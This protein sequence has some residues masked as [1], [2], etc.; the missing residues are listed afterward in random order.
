MEKIKQ[1][2]SQALTI[3]DA[4]ESL[5]KIADIDFDAEIAIGE[6]HHLVIQDQ[7]IP[8]QKV[9]FLKGANKQATIEALR[10]I[11]QT[12]LDY[13]RAFAKREYSRL[14]EDQG[15]DDIHTM[16]TLVNEA[17]KKID[18]YC[19]AFQS[20][21]GGSVTDLDE[22]SQLIA[23][24]EQIVSKGDKK[25]EGATSQLAEGQGLQRLFSKVVQPSDQTVRAIAERKLSPQRG[26]SAESHRVYV[27]V[28]SVKKDREYELFF[29]RKRAGERYYSD[30]LVRNLRLVCDFGDIFVANQVKDP[31]VQTRYWLDKA[32]QVSA[33]NMIKGVKADLDEFY[34]QA[35][36]KRDRML[37]THLNKA[38]MAL[39]LAANPH[40]LEKSSRLK[41]CTK[42][43]LDFQR[44]FREALECEEYQKLN[45]KRPKA[46]QKYEW[47]LLNL[48]HHLCEALYTQCLGYQEFNNAMKI[49][50][51]KGRE[52]LDIKEDAN[53]TLIE[54]IEEDF[55]AL[56]EVVKLHLNGPLHKILEELELKRGEGF[57]SI[58]QSNLPHPLYHMMIG[59]KQSIHLRL[60]SPT[61]QRMVNKAVI[62]AEFEGMIEA[63]ANRGKSLLVF[64]LQDRTSWKEHAR[65]DVLEGLQSKRD[66][67]GDIVVVTLPMDTDFYHQYAPYNH[68]NI[69]EQFT[70]QLLDHIRDDSS[71][72]YFPPQVKKVILGEFIDQLVDGI[73]KFI[74]EGRDL[75]T[76]EERQG[77]IDLVY[78][79]IELKVLELVKPDTFAF[80]D[81]DG[82]DTGPAA[83]TELFLFLHQ[84]N[85][86]KNL[87]KEIEFLNMMLFSPS[88]IIRERAIFENRFNRMVQTVNLIDTLI[89]II[90]DKRF[91]EGMQSYFAPLFKTKILNTTTVIS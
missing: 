83:S 85:H 22:Y 90:G 36:K 24:Y 21:E 16:M 62:T 61:K 77:F 60:P 13:M 17:G 28:D 81:K 26:S 44:Y 27:D 69:S 51:N 39:H 58:M 59:N 86:M 75:M 15:L 66:F 35:M 9:H 91:D 6:N 56:K 43:F 45:T 63:Y 40:N 89:K 70:T 41:N 8:F 18:L 72:F 71:G 76:I 50:I 4:V 84:I 73:H 46:N 12:I 42:Y 55:A 52:I 48:T 88:V 87:K 64:N 33:V 3:V 14:N 29:L 7:E 74:F 1:I 2:D 34:E 68:L 25:K 23:F 49:L 11:F 47:C 31:L 30:N 10:K 54:H 80:T 57:D 67:K 53:L 37:V 38:I 32:F 82:I 5:S 65:C 19:S 20:G 78:L 79:F